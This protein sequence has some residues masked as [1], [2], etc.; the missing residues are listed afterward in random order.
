VQFRSIEEQQ[1][2]ARQRIM[3]QPDRH[4]TV[5]VRGMRD[6]VMIITPDVTSGRVSTE[7]LEAYRREQLAKWPF[8][9][10]YEEAHRRLLERK[11]TLPVAAPATEPEPASY[12]RRVTKPRA[13]MKA[14]ASGKE[15]PPEP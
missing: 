4:A 2:R 8:S 9:L 12:K 15:Q 11:K 10:S 1:F 13:T 7:V 5:R 14:H 3:F 6:P